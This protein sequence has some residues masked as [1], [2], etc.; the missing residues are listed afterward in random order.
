MF[1]ALDKKKKKKKNPAEIKRG[2]FVF[3]RFHRK[4]FIRCFFCVCVI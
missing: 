3:L 2:G 1:R 4:Y